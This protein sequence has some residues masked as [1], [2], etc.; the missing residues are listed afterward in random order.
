MDFDELQKKIDKTYD[1]WESQKENTHTRS[2]IEFSDPEVKS[3]Y[4]IINDAIR[5]FVSQNN[6]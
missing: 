1:E 3:C 5:I 4:Q 2:Y 6:L